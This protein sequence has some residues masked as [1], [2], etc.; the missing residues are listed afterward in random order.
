MPFDG[1]LQS[2]QAVATHEDWDLQGLSWDRRAGP[3]GDVGESPG[4]ML[5]GGRGAWR[6]GRGA[7]SWE[8]PPGEGKRRDKKE[9]CVRGNSSRK[10][11]EQNENWRVDKRT[12]GLCLTLKAANYRNNFPV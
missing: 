4:E 6:R 11:K 5:M 8:T 3:A 10:R 9:K 1:S 12:K 7:G 2:E